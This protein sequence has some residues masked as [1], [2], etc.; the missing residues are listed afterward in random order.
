MTTPIWTPD[1]HRRS[2]SQVE[3]F[4]VAVGVEGGYRDLHR[5]S[6]DHPGD[7]WRAV[8]DNLGVVGYP[9]DR[10]IQ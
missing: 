8:W 9:G 4:R 7:F 5:W 1:V 2:T 6:V 3:E 10:P